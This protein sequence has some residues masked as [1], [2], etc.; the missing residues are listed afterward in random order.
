MNSFIIEQSIIRLLLFQIVCFWLQKTLRDEKTLST[1]FASVANCP[2]VSQF[3]KLF[4][5]LI[6]H[7]QIDNLLLMKIPTNWF[8]IQFAQLN[9]DNYKHFDLFIELK[10][11]SVVGQFSGF[12]CCFEC[13]G[14]LFADGKQPSHDFAGKPE[15]V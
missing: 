12:N 4:L 14:T 3:N 1:F 6:T 15:N 7:L 2:N 11:Q 10:A 13:T 9:E 8:P 5:K